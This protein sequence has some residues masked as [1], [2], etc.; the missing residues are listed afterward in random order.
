MTGDNTEAM[1]L[2]AFGDLRY[3][4]ELAEEMGA[5][6]RVPGADLNLEIGA[7]YELSLSK[8][9]PPV[10]LFEDIVGGTPGHRIATNVRSFPLLNPHY[11]K[12]LEEVKAYR[13]GHK[14][15]PPPI[16][17]V[18]VE[19]GPVF[20]NRMTG[21]AID[22]EI[23]PAPKWHADDGGRYIGTEHLVIMRDPDT[24]WINAGTYRVQVH[25]KKTLGV[26]IEPGK[27]GDIIRRKY[28][29]RGEACPVAI[30]VGQAPAL[31]AVGA[32]T[33]PLGVSEYAVAGGRIG[34][35]VEVVEGPVTGLPF[36][37]DSEIVFE[38]VMP[39]PEVEARPEGPFGEWPGYYASAERPEPVLRVEACYHRDDPIVT[40]MP[41]AKPTYPGTY[42][43][44]AGT[45][46]FR[47][48]SLWDE[49]EAAGIPGVAGAWKM[50]GGGSRFIDVVAIKQLHAGHAK[51]AGLVAAGCSAAA[52]AGRMTIIVDD[53]IDIT[54]TAEVMWAM[55]TRWDPAT[56]TDIIDDARSGNID[57][58][59][60]P[61]KR[62]ARN[63][64]NSRIIIYAVRPWHWKDEFPKVN[65]VD[66]DYAE[67]VRR[68][69]AGE[70]PFLKKEA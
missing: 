67:E 3:C 37:A 62:R 51:M 40:A 20:E 31:S 34:R 36:P 12:G 21:E 18:T 13:R 10:L 46:L 1:R 8:A 7:L 35:P 6:E 5:L 26:M 43:G 49:L 42:Y 2:A 39:P 14:E 24:G 16:D 23:F 61:E 66:R 65:M 60:P 70:L 22:A 58:R 69:W 4:L 19:T 53:D 27:H 47:A 25:D 11:G 63:L 41:P 50:P 9:V 28:W 68:K 32:T 30:S 45:S 57:P 29:A 15:S 52:F 33:V 56:Q 17:P 54:D 48:A 44:T 64:T 38:G 55:A 59:V